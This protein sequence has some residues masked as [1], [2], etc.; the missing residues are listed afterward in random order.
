MCTVNNKETAVGA[1]DY[2]THTA[3]YECVVNLKLPESCFTEV[4]LCFGCGVV[5]LLRRVC[6]NAEFLF[7]FAEIDVKHLILEKGF[8]IIVFDVK[9]VKE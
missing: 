6:N 7:A 4:V 8:M 5:T 1:S 2:V 9:T 3:V